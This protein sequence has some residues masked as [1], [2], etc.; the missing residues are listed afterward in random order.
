[1]MGWRITSVSGGGGEQARHIRQNRTT[2][3]TRSFFIS[4][5]LSVRV[6]ARLPATRIADQPGGPTLKTAGPRFRRIGIGPGQPACPARHAVRGDQDVACALAKPLVTRVD[7][8]DVAAVEHQVLGPHA[9]DHPDVAD[10]D[11]VLA[12]ATVKSRPW[13]LLSG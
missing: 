2:G 11:G 4:G 13:G 1:V 8:A 5:V 6:K 9:L 10:V 12:R 3:A 7:L